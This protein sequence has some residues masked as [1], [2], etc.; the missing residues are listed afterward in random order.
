M[1]CQLCL[2]QKT[3]LKKSHI[4]PKFMYEGL[5][6]KSHRIIEVNI[7]D[8][9]GSKKQRLD[10]YYDREI[11]CQ[12]CDNEILGALETYASK[13]LYGRGNPGKNRMPEVRYESNESLVS[14]IYNNLDYTQTKLFLLSILWRAHIS[15]LSFFDCI[16]LG[17]YAERIREMLLSGDA[18]KDD[19]LETCLIVFSANS[20]TPIQSVV[21]PRCLKIGGNQSYVFFINGIMYHYNL[22][23]YN[24]MSIFDKGAIAANNSMNVA[25]VEGEFANGYFDSFLGR[26]LRLR[27]KLA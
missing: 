5:F 1:T 16:Q 22:S 14:I 8:I 26:K 27:S 15:K 19:E 18:G 23:Q 21:E 13:A 10:G 4:I 25:I 7:I 17:P 9:D 12:K 11:L 3:L 6:D 24:K 2:E 20:A